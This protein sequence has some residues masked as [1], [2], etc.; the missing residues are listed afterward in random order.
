MVVAVVVVCPSV[1]RQAGLLGGGVRREGHADV[2]ILQMKR[3][4]NDRQIICLSHLSAQTIQS[5]DRLLPAF[6]IIRD[7]RK[8][9]EREERE[10]EEECKMKK[11]RLPPK[12]G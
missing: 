4:G 8:N 10:G 5:I 7:E 2:L 12:I 6:A 11:D 9:E 3:R 1:G